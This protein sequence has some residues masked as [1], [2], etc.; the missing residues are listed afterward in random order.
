MLGLPL[1]KREGGI[2]SGREN[3]VAGTTERQIGIS[4]NEALENR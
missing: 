1:E 3:R 2:G 4:E